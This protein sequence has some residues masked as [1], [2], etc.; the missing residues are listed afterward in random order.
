MHK[1]VLINHSFQSNYF[2]RRWELFANDHKDFDVTLLSPDKYEWYSGKSYTYSGG[3][4]LSGKKLDKNNFHMRTFRLRNES[5][6]T[7][8]DYKE[9]FDE[10]QPD[11]IYFIGIHNQGGLWQILRL[12]ND[13][14]PHTKVMSFSMRGPVFNL[15][16]RIKGVDLP[17]K[18]WRIYQYYKAK[19]NLNFFNKNINAVFCHYPDAVDCFRQ[20]G[21]TGPIYMQTQV[22]VN[23]EWFAPNKVYRDEIRQKYVIPESTFVFGSATRF[24]K[25]KGLDDIL[26]ALPND[27]DWKYLM[28][29]T[30]LE[31][32]QKRLKDLI[33]ERGLEE[34]VVLTGM[35]DWYDMAKYWNAVDCAIHVPRTTEHWV[36]T[37]SLSAVQPQAT[38]KPVI[39]NTSGSVPYQIGI[40]EMIVTEGDVAKLHEKIKWVF[41]HKQEAEEI[42]IKMYERTIHSFSIKHLN[43][44]FYRTLVEDIL[45]GK[46]DSRKSDMTKWKENE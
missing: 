25:D 12:R 5:H 23:T 22:G 17:H 19:K 41:E 42:G 3:K 36:E 28:M 13:F 38:K 21:Y 46:Y 29:G 32:D 45:P 4:T 27:G 35:V 7:S 8:D 15:K 33:K 43:E 14:Y 10:I 24:T 44:L 1:I 20:E 6:W 2:S 39:G 11:I 18:I 30:G 40:K 31:E 37:F 16:L 9:I 26:N 34:K